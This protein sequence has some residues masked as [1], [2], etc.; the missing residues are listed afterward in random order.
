ML[1]DF[2]LAIGGESLVHLMA[3]PIFA[4]ADLFIAI[5]GRDSWLHTMFD[6]LW[7]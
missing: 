4:F 7:S 2:F 5:V 6:F 3:G 1:F